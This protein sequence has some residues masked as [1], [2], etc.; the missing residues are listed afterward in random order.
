MEKL[1]FDDERHEYL[2]IGD[3]TLRSLISVTTLLSKHG[4]APNYGTIPPNILRRKADY[5]TYVHKELEEWV[6]E[7]KIG[8]SRELHQ[9]MNLCKTVGLQPKKSEFL[10]HN[11]IVAG[12]VDLLADFHGMTVLIDYKTTAKLHKDTVSWQ[13]SLYAS[14]C[15]E[16]IDEIWA[17]HFDGKNATIV[18][19]ERKPKYLIDKLLESERNGKKYEN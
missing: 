15:E 14:M 9:F 8:F 18:P 17:I 2:L 5:G 7:G 12:T 13:L 11:D 19:L 6:K 16:H 4:L 3:H 1:Y 10:V